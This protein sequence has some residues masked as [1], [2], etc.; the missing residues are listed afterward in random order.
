MSK[1]EWGNPME[2]LVRL[3]HHLQSHL[4][5]TSKCLDEWEDILRRCWFEFALDR[6]NF[7]WYIYMYIMTRF[8]I[9]L[10]NAPLTQEGGFIHPKS[11]KES[12]KFFIVTF[13]FNNCINICRVLFWFVIMRAPLVDIS[14]LLPLPPDSVTKFTQGTAKRNYD[15]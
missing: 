10:V 12:K 4:E 8:T 13:F 15:E 11:K 3:S 1:H 9:F 2:S 5:F 6:M 7:Y 14:W